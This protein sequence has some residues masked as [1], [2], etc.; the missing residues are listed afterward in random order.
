MDFALSEEQKATQNTIKK[1]IARECTREAA[2]ELDERG[3]FPEILFKTVADMGICALTIALEYDGVGPNTLAAVMAAEE[4]AAINPALAGALMHAAFCGG[5]NISAL[6][7]E[8]QKKKYLPQLAVGSLLF[9]YGITEADSGYAP[10]P[11]INTTAWPDGDQFILN[12]RKS[13]VRLAERADYILTLAVTDENG[14]AHKNQS[15]LIV[16]M[17]RPGISINK[18]ETVGFKSYSLA[19][20][21]FENVGVPRENVLGGLDKLNCGWDQYA[22]IMETE[23]L[24]IAACSLGLAQGAYD[25]AKNYARER[26]QFGKPII[27]FEA[28][29]NMLVDMATAIQASRLLAYQAAWMADNSES[30]VLEAAMAR[31]YAAE[32]ARKAC[33]QALQIFGGYGYA[34]EYDVQRYVRDSLVLLGGGKPVEVLKNSIGSMLD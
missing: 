22:K 11:V 26:V 19:E 7:N 13:L 14:E 5:R 31:T 18:I 30:C 10:I 17:H 2:R 27:K 8:E 12:G 4:V 15:F 21:V 29:Q 16:D 9:T 20:V 32:A 28:V 1:F 3:E 23:H 6:G 33:F 34:M 25:Y 24:E